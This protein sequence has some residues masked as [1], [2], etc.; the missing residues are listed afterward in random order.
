MRRVSVGQGSF[1]SVCQVLAVI[2]WCGSTSAALPM[3]TRSTPNS[4][5]RS[6]PF[7]LS[8]GHDMP[9]RLVVIEISSSTM[10]SSFFSVKR[11]EKVNMS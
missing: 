1:F 9:F 8:Y 3:L 11:P 7:A 6:N 2:V 4:L 10:A 5:K